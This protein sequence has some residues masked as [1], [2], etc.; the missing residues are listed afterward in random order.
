MIRVEGL[1]KLYG[2][3]KA[4]D[5]LSFEVEDGEIVGLLGPNGAGKTTTMKILT[6]FMPATFGKA[7]IAGHDIFEEPM[8]VKRQLGYLPENPPLYPEMSV[9]GYVDFVAELK[10]VPGRDRSKKV[11]RALEETGTWD[12]KDRLIAHLSRGYQQRVG[13]AQALVHDPRLLILDEPTTGLDPKQIIEIRELIRNLGQ[14][15]TVIL[16]THILPEVHMTCEKILVINEGRIVGSGTESELSK[17]VLGADHYVLRARGPREE[18][19][20][21]LADIEGVQRVLCE[22]NQEDSE[23]P[24]FFIETD[25][26]ADPRGPMFDLMSKKKWPI[27]ELRPPEISLE[28]VFIKLT[29][30]DE[31][32]RRLGTL[33]HHPEL[34]TEDKSSDSPAQASESE[35]SQTQQ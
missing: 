6:C 27:L 26:G 35:D 5:K 22:E 23:A 10:E 16:S 7:W 17:E 28:Q 33:T 12:V 9:R 14:E 20:K 4:I 30:G 3:F 25:S 18:L 19:K 1:T 11:R 32:T 15:R 8:A 31:E 29:T 24:L 2:D 21:R 34:G 13:L